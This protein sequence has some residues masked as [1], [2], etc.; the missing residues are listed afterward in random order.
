MA[1]LFRNTRK[2][3]RDAAGIKSSSMPWSFTNRRQVRRT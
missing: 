3:P 2:F 1:T